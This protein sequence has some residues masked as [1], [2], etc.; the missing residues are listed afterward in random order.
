[1]SNFLPDG[2]EELQTSK[3][4]INLPK[5]PEGEYKFRIVTRPIAGWVDWKDKKPFRFRPD[6][7]PSA[8]FVEDKP[9]KAFWTCYVWDYSQ[10]GLFIMEITQMGVLKGL[11][12]LG[13]S[14][15][16][17]DFTTYD[18]KIKKEGSGKETKYS[19]IPVPH[20]PMI[21]KI[22]EALKVKPVNLEAL[23][24]GGDPWKDLDDSWKEID[25]VP[26]SIDPMEKLKQSMLK[27]NMDVEHLD[28]FIENI[29]KEKKQ[30][31]MNI[32]S[33]ALLPDLLP[34]FIKKY[35]TWTEDR[36]LAY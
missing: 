24:K 33:A 35:I 18:I 32:I 7:K 14:E 31:K 21:E 12:D 19:V 25:V 29:S 9:V 5:L 6:S 1:M 36:E 28:D 11:V 3:S 10:D 34:A 15:D 4:Y 2:F 30:A 20:K 13:K 8:P 17:G 16:W 26:V 23:Y 22:K 27:H